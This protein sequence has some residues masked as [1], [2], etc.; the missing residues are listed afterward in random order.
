MQLQSNWAGVSVLFI[1]TRAQRSFFCT[2]ESFVQRLANVDASLP[3]VAYA[4]YVPSSCSDIHCSGIVLFYFRYV[5]C[6]NVCVQYARTCL[7]VFVLS[8]IADMSVP[9]Y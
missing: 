5:I 7:C 3:T 6:V 8:G 1:F 4:L 2:F 9:I